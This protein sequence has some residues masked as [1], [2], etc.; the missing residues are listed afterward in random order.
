MNI[1]SHVSLSFRLELTKT[2]LHLE[3]TQQFL[4]DQALEKCKKLL[5]EREFHT[6]ASL[7]GALATVFEISEEDL[8]LKI[9]D[10][11]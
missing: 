7:I 11:F 6:A 2:P 1:F 5:P 3:S 8:Q 9:R 10:C 4:E